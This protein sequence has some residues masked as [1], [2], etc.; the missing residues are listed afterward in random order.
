MPSVRREYHFWVYLLA[1]RS[2][3]LYVGMTN[4]LSARLRMH[5]DNVGSAHTAKYNINRLVYFEYHRYVRNAIGRENALKRLS[6]AEKI[7]LIEKTNPTWE[8]LL[9]VEPIT[10]PL[11]QTAGSPFGE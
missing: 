6:R 10:L 8:D 7:A 4:N 9:P 3:N 1:S 5:R 2:R 11:K